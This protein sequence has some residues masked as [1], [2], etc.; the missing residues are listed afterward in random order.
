MSPSQLGFSNEHAPQDNEPA[1]ARAQHA[2]LLCS[3]KTNIRVVEASP[4]QCLVNSTLRT[5]TNSG[6]LE[7]QRRRR[8]LP[9]DL[10]R[11]TR[12][13][14]QKTT[15][16]SQRD[17]QLHAAILHADPTNRGHAVRSF[18]LVIRGEGV[19]QL[20]QPQQRRRALLPDFAARRRRSRSSRRAASCCV[21]RRWN[22]RTHH[23]RR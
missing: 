16:I 11:S 22:Q 2:R 13:M 18:K 9:L 5:Q 20:Q 17:R 7:C 3:T 19:P 8:L 14:P 23:L 6:I 1:V 21:Q 12:E 15:A 4:R 10:A